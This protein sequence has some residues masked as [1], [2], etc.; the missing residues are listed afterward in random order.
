MHGALSRTAIT[1]QG[2][3]GVSAVSRTTRVDA[4]SSCVQRQRMWR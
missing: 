4:D 3:G 2:D 1:A